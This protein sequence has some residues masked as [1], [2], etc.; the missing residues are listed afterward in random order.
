[1]RDTYVQCGSC[2]V[3]GFCT[4]TEAECEAYYAGFGW[5]KDREFPGCNT[6]SVS[7]CS[8]TVSECEA[9]KEI[10]GVGQIVFADAAEPQTPTH[11][12]PANLGLM[13]WFTG[14]IDRISTGAVMALVTIRCGDQRLTSM[15]PVSKLHELQYQV[16]DTVSV[17]IKAVN[18]VLMR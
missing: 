18:V 1:M 8:Q 13:N 17:A 2:E 10:N 14:V 16:G 7:L 5:D 3:F 6:C 12:L 9:Y 4:Q 15:V 11:N